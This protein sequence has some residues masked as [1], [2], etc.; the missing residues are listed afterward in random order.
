MK[1]AG[2]LFSDLGTLFAQPF[3]TCSKTKIGSLCVDDANSHG[4]WIKVKQFCED[5]GMRLPDSDEIMTLYNQGVIERQNF[6][7]EEL[8]QEPPC[9]YSI[10]NVRLNCSDVYSTHSGQTRC[11]K[12]N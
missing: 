3:D 12:G 8:G 4:S 1:P 10:S 7:V 2:E 9:L 5:K 6:W 11:V